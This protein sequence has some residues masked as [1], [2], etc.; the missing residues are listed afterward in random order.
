MTAISKE[1]I[2]GVIVC[3][4]MFGCISISNAQEKITDKTLMNL[5]SEAKEYLEKGDINNA[6]I[7]ILDTYEKAAKDKGSLSPAATKD[8]S[9]NLFKM[10]EAVH[11][12]DGADKARNWLEKAIKGKRGQISE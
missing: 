1:K 3:V 5:N 8:L 2:I 6:G 7:K 10:G 11:K 9:D 4:F 12:K